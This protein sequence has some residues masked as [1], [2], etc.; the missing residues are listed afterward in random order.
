MLP[1]LTSAIVAGGRGPITSSYRNFYSSTSN[2]SSYN[3][4]SSDIGDA[5]ADRYI[6]VTVHGRTGSSGTYTFNTCTVGGASCTRVLNISGVTANGNIIAMFVT[7]N[8]FTAGTTATIAVSTNVAIL[9]CAVGVFAVYG[10][11]SKT[12]NAT[13]TV[14]SASNPS[15]SIDV[16]SGGFL[17]AHLTDIGNTTCTWTG[18]TERYDTKVESEIRSGASLDTTTNTTLTVTA[19]PASDSGIGRMLAAAWWPE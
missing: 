15:G 18:P 3:F 6:V 7:D 13:I 19:D 2:S 10:L 17:V 9:N 4:A 16:K 5:A 11:V 14:N 12:P 8:P 1:G